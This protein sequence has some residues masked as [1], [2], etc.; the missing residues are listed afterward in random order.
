MRLGEQTVL[1]E[2]G[3]DVAHGGG[4]LLDA[5]TLDQGARRAAWPVTTYSRTDR[6]QE[7]L[8]ARAQWFTRQGPSSADSPLRIVATIRRRA[9]SS[10]SESPRD[11]GTM[12]ASRRNAALGL[13]RAQPGAEV[14]ERVGAEALPVGL[15]LHAR[16]G[17]QAEEEHPRRE[18]C[19]STSSSVGAPRPR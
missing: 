19:S 6:R 8:R 13:Q 12:S 18:A 3:H 7:L 4:A 5:V 15:A 16:D 11:V 17:A 10:A 14:V 2:L 1:L 9:S